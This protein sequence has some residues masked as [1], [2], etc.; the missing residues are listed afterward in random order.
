MS[1]RFYFDQHVPGPVR[2][3]LRRR[4][5]DILSTEEDGAKGEPDERLLE[6]ATELERVMVTN[7]EDF[8]VIASRWLAQGRHFAGMVRL[9][10]QHLPYRKVVED[11]SMLAEVYSPAEMIDRIEYLP[12]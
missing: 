9:R 3:S 11:L 1:L 6:R 8:L 10:D 2:S 4:G 7:D 5:A 12:L